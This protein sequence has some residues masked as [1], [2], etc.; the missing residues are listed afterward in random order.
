MF[1]D[2]ELEMAIHK[3]YAKSYGYDFFVC[4]RG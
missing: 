3:K 2:T 4:R 1:D